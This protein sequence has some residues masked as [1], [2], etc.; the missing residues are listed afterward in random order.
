MP[1][2]ANLSAMTP[3]QLAD[4]LR[5]R[6]F[7]FKL[8]AEALVKMGVPV[9]ADLVDRPGGFPE[10]VVVL[11]D[12]PA[13]PNT[14]QSWLSALPLQQP[15]CPHENIVEWDVV[16]MPPARFCANCGVRLERSTGV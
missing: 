4:A 5:L 13:A 7:E 3:E 6:A 15:N 2:P 9:Q 16:G 8:I 1:L 10:I 14:P 11:P 12:S